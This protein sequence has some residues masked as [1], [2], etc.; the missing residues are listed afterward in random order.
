[1]DE[2]DFVA[3]TVY[4]ERGSHLK[5]SYDSPEGRKREQDI[6]IDQI[7]AIFPHDSANTSQFNLCFVEVNI[8]SSGEH[9]EEHTHFRSLVLTEP[10]DDLVADFAAT[11]PSF[12][13]DSRHSQGNSLDCGPHTH[14]IISTGSGFASADTCY[15]N[16]LNPFL[17]L[18]NC[19]HA[20]HR[21]TSSHSILELTQS[22]FLP[23]AAAGIKKFIILLSGDGGVVDIVNGML[24]PA[25]KNLNGLHK[26]LPDLPTVFVKPS[27]ALLPMGTGNALAN[28]SGI[29]ADKTLGMSSLARGHSKPLPLFGVNFDP[30]AVSYDPD[31]PSSSFDSTSERVASTYGAVVFSWALHAALVAD[32]DTPEYRKHGTERFK[33]AAKEN[34]FPTDGGP[35][36]LYEGELRLSEATSGA[37]DKGRVLAPRGFNYLLATFCAQLEKE[38]YVSPASKPLDG[39]LRVVAFGD[40][41]SGQD[42][43]DLMTKAYQG[44]KHVDDPKV[45]YKSVGSLTV[46]GFKDKEERWRRVC[47]D[48]RILVVEPGSTVTVWKESIEKSILDLVVL[49]Q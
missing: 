2:K 10:S 47:I 42:I 13:H 32:S 43:I 26:E 37:G 8:Q 9:A 40:L 1:M 11:I 25:L 41:E 23:A 5:I 45:S 17:E 28:S 27:F 46:T 35:V 49:E 31:A 14:I 7:I 6:Q 12:W 20:L 38:F 30:P 19:S 36:H 44:G 15:H 4:Y 29:L 33:L 21:T 3:T 24:E 18:I 22:V 39:Q 48:G 34:L 16:I